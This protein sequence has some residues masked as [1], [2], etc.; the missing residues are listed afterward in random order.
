MQ[1]PVL[2][3][4]LERVVEVVL[5]PLEEMHQQHHLLKGVTEVLVAHQQY[6]ASRLLMLGVAVAEDTTLP[7]PVVQE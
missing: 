2:A 4:N 3:L 5:A 6:Q 1:H 7:I